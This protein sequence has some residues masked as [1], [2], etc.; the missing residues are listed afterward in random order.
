MATAGGHELICN[1][2]GLRPDEWPPDHYRLLGLPPG[3]DDPALIERHVH[4]R[5]DA[6]RC[7]QMLHP[8]QATE[9]MNRLAQAFVCLT[10]P[11]AKRMYDASLFGQAAPAVLVQSPPP[12]PAGAPAAWQ[13]GAAVA[14]PPLPVVPPPLPPPVPGVGETAADA[15]GAMAAE[16]PVPVPPPLPDLP[17]LPPVT[18][19]AAPPAPEPVPREPVDPVLQAARDSLAARV[20][21][22]TKRALYRRVARTRQLLRTWARIGTYL[23]EPKRRPL[24]RAEVRDLLKRIE[25]FR[26]LLARFPPL[27]GEAGQPG[28]LVLQ[29]DQVDLAHLQKIT[30]NQRETLSNDWKAGQK[31]LLAHR[32]F[33]RQEIRA[34]RKRPLKERLLLAA[35]TY[36]NEF[37]GAI[38][39][40]L[41]V[42]ALGIAVWRSGH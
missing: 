14:P 26:E 33:L 19:A 20:G 10:E 31:L 36:V 16:P 4:Q 6:V 8:E 11:S 27:L 38:L 13:N 37:P 5:L 24:R 35:R 42:L 18:A 40:I 22:G 41:G 9:A 15:A 3:A 25:E 21:L 2:L 39:L 30:A 17:P 32:E 23:S 28:Y 1:W 29:L 7:Y 12:P 34:L